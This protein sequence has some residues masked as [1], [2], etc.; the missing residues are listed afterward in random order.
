MHL[1]SIGDVVVLWDAMR[2]AMAARG[3]DWRLGTA[4]STAAC[5]AYLQRTR[6]DVVI[7]QAQ[8]D[9]GNALEVINVARLHGDIPVLVVALDSTGEE[10][11]LP[12]LEAG[13]KGFIDRTASMDELLEAAARV[14]EGKTHI[15]Q[16]FAARLAIEYRQMSQRRPAPLGLTE[17]ELGVLALLA[18][19]YSN[20]A[21]ARALVVSE[22]TVRAHLRNI[23]RKLNV[24]NRVQAVARVTR[25]GILAALPLPES[26]PETAAA[27]GAG[28][29]PVVALPA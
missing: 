11:F 6:P 26:L 17:R 2:E 21:I 4:E 24:E 12:A 3:L 18:H 1:F 29:Q 7:T 5:R 19:G 8:F 20:K 9:E 14:A 25:E 22:H 28:R 16:R 27:P 13:A 23:M 15:P 10:M